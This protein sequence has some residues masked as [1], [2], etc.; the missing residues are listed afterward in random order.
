VLSSAP[1]VQRANRCHPR[2]VELS[3]TREIGIIVLP[4]SAASLLLLHSAVRFSSTNVPPDYLGSRAEGE[5]R[6][7]ERRKQPRT[8]PERRQTQR[9]HAAVRSVVLAAAAVA[10]PHHVKPQSLDVVSSSAPTTVVT[11]TIE[12]VVSVPERVVSVPSEHAYDEFIREAS[13]RYRVDATLIRS[14]MQTESA[15]DAMAVSPAGALGL[16]QLMPELA[17]ELGVEDPLDPR[18]NIMGG[19]KYLRRLLDLHRGNVRLALA[20]YNAGPT[21]VSQYGGVPPFPETQKYVKKVTRL[22]KSSRR[23]RTD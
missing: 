6:K 21:N 23:A 16:M 5:R 20:S 4:P 11:T 13:T 7:G 17:A 18:Q 19:V 2:K 8:G 12:R 14:V 10:M 15:F 1:A 3:E 9:R 22:V